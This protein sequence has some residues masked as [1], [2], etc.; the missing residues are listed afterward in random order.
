VT[1][2]KIIE[3]ERGATWERAPMSAIRKGDRF[4]WWEDETRTL[5]AEGFVN[6]CVAQEDAQERDG[7]WG[8]IVKYEEENP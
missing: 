7:V 8:V 2:K 6:V 4:R 3:V 1:E 5:P